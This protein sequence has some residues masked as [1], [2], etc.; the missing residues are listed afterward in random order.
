MNYT[1][2]LTDWQT[3]YHVAFVLKNGWD[4]YVTRMTELKSGGDYGSV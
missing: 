4:K 2:T 3:M 1:L